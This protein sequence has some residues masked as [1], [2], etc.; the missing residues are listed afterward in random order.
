[1][2]PLVR[3]APKGQRYTAPNPPMNRPAAD[4]HE[5]CEGELSPPPQQA[6]AEGQ[7]AKAERKQAKAERQRGTPRAKLDADDVR[8]IRRLYATGEWG[9]KDLAYIYGVTQPT[10]SAVVNGK[11][12]RDVGDETHRETTERED[13]A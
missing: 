11:T 2:K 1:M 9:V 7:Q 13:G 5:P 6:K 8:E 10:M 4:L 3:R 12:W